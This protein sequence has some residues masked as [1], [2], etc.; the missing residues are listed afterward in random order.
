MPEIFI[1]Y[2]TGRGDENAAALL[3]HHLSGRFGS[4]KVFYA[5]KSISPGQDF[6]DALSSASG[7]TKV[8]LVVMGPDWLKRDEHGEHPL[9]D[10]E[11]WTRREILN[12]LESGAHVIPILCG[13]KMPRLSKSELPAGLERLADLQSRP[14]DSGNADSCL[15]DIANALAE[16]VPSLRDGVAEA[17]SFPS[18]S[19]HNDISGTV[20]GAAV[21]AGAVHQKGVANGGTVINGPTGPVHTGKGSVH[22]GHIFNGGT[23]SYVEGSNTGGVHQN[24]GAQDDPREQ[25]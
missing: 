13:R 11:N 16:L 9:E 18:A 2:R 1:N 8:L 10:E 6:R 4:E 15:K 17:P 21:Q 19:T 3:D 20:E 25:R 23:T 5:S 24:F 7:T 14:F 22:V 12:A